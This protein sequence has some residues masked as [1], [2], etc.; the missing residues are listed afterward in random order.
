[1]TTKLH[2]VFSITILFVC[3]YGNAQSDY[4][5]SETKR[6]V[7]MGKSVQN[8]EAVK[9]KIFTLKQDD[10][11][12][13]LLAIGSF[14]NSSR[15]VYFPNENGE[16]VPFMVSESSVLSPSLAQKY[17]KIK[18]YMGHSLLNKGDRIRFSVSHNGIQSMVVYADSRHTTFIQK[19][20]KE[21][22]DYVVY[23]KDAK[24]NANTNFICNTKS[25]VEKNLGSTSLKLVDD[26]TLKKYRIAVSAT[27][28]Y[29]AFHG[30]TVA[31]GLAAI[32]AT[33]TRVNEVFETDLGVTLE[34]VPNNDLIIF[35]DAS[36]DPYTGNLNVQAQSTLSSIIGEANYDVGHVFNEDVNNGNAGSIGS[37]CVNGIKGG[38]FSSGS[39]PEGDVFD[40]DFVAH[41]LGHQFGAN[42][43]WSFDFEGTLVQAEPG[44][45]TTIMGYAGIAGENNV[46]PD[47]DD[48]FHYNSILQITEYLETTSCAVETALTNNPP[49]I[50]SQGNFSIPKS[51]AFVLTG[52]ATDVDGDI[53][54]YAW[55]QI[56]DGLVT[57]TTFG[58][59]NPGGANFRSQRPSSSPQRFFP[60]LSSVAQ[61]NLT[62]TN[63]TIN[64]AWETVSDIERDMNFALT[65]RDN[66]KFISLSISETVSQAEFMVGLV[67]V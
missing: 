35:T 38:A 36:T 24:N 48:Y 14:K 11:E 45:G 1:M 43:T 19:T 20:S 15:T 52:D 26:Q 54:T 39:P 67:W 28:E 16:L 9:T 41:E 31:D 42:H 50:N 5:R 60:Q 46:A 64:S 61:G 34:L 25:E 12:R 2:L 4:W 53:L 10:F 8:L 30:G 29:T 33:L 44:S 21:G 7:F 51:T 23:S 17:P 66:A 62:Q 18:S 55:E 56:D 63:P 3:F 37:V 27:G 49:V 32:N 22:D 47:G 40:L 58:P 6:K 65:V 57:T 13:H 59:T